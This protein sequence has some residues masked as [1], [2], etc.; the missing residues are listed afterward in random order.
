M[1]N[2]STAPQ[3][4]IPRSE[5]I[6]VTLTAI[7]AGLSIFGGTAICILYLTFKDLRSP[8]RQLLLYVAASDALLALG[9]LLG[10]IWYLYSDYA[11]I[12][13]SEG[14]C[15]FQ[16][17]MTIYFSMTSFSWTVIMGVSL[18]AAVVL[19]KAQFTATYMKLFHIVSWI[20]PGIITV[21]ALC[22]GVL[23]TDTSLETA[24]W[25]WIDPRSP[26]V[27]LWQ[28]ATGKFL[29]IAAY[30]ATV[31]LYTAIKVFLSRQAKKKIRMVTRRRIRKDVM[32]EAN[33]KLTFVPL[34]FIVCRIWGTLRFLIG[35]FGHEIVNKPYVTWINP[36]QGIGDSA[37]G[38]A[39]F[40]LYCYSTESIRR[41]MFRHLKCFNKVGP[42]TG[43][44]LDIG[45]RTITAG[46]S[47]TV[48]TKAAS[49]TPM[50]PGPE[51]A[52][53]GPAT[54][55]YPSEMTTE[56]GDVWIGPPESQNTYSSNLVRVKSV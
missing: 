35:N 37:Q 19:G 20:P 27:L 26:H 47:K 50:P 55:I 21:V 2:E 12:N 6:Y 28:F 14:Y 44:S 53:H 24:S 38:I 3:H 8:A 25:C 48:H 46:P 41:R 51:S 11:V 22:L 10:I 32:D 4:G 34:V 13:K 16:S 36:L 43:V 9:N 18:F 39:N 49:V 56:T 52:Q 23:G 17:A 54:L 7:T 5:Y 42:E 33:R 30:I 1:L 40:V 15:D 45:S 29:E 31:V